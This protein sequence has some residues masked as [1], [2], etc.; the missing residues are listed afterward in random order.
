MLGIFNFQTSIPPL[1]R[2]PELREN[3][4]FVTG[5]GVNHRLIKFGPI[6]QAFDQPKTPSVPF[7]HAIARSDDAP[8]VSLAKEKWLAG[9]SIWRT[10]Y[11]FFVEESH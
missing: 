4:S 8:E 7:V 3:T 2:Y 10:G 1:G 9:S 6:V 11:Y 5:R